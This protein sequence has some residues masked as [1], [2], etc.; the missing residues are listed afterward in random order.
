MSD[1]S[2][3]ADE[4]LVS[5]EWDRE[6]WLRRCR[7]SYFAIKELEWG[8]RFRSRFTNEGRVKVK[9]NNHTINNPLSRF[10]IG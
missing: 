6:D 1:D 2:F 10:L 9:V 4:M 7:R 8:H 5:F 3:P